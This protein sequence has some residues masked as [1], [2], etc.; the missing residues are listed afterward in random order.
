MLAD[1]QAK[2][3]R[4]QEQINALDARTRQMERSMLLYRMVRSVR[5]L[6]KKPLP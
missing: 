2:F 4:V 3:R 6:F 5:R 1:S